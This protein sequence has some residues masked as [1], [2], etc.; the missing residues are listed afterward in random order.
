MP[1][2][3]IDPNDLA[4]AW[5]G[6]PTVT[7]EGCGICAEWQRG[8]AIRVLLW[9]GPTAPTSHRYATAAH[10]CC[11]CGEPL[12]HRT[13]APGGHVTEYRGHFILGT[14]L[15]FCSPCNE[16]ILSTEEDLVGAILEVANDRNAPVPARRAAGWVLNRV[17]A[18]V[19]RLVERGDNNLA[20]YRMARRLIAWRN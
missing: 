18:F 9:P 11:L 16:A 1:V 8:G 19:G 5:S 12:E 13:I 17:A 3:V 14:G 15:E 10:T 4:L 2:Q 7:A 6:P 20:T